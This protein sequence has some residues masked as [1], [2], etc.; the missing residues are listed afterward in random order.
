MEIEYHKIGF[1]ILYSPITD[2]LCRNNQYND[3]RKIKKTQKPH[4]RKNPIAIII[5][6][7]FTKCNIKPLLDT[8][9]AYISTTN[10]VYKAIMLQ[11]TP[12][13][14]FLLGHGSANW[15]TQPCAPRWPQTQDQTETRLH[16]VRRLTPNL[17]PTATY[18]NLFSFI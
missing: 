1:W 7:S 16:E 11:L 13:A 17:T 15:P 3:S 18:L 6:A 14:A 5:Q 10:I 4:S 2:R 8:F 9:P 12:P